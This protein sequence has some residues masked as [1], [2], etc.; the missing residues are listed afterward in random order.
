MREGGREGGREGREEREEK[1]ISRLTSIVFLGSSL[2]T[3]YL[4]SSI[5]AL[6][7][8]GEINTI[9]FTVL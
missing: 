5:T 1:E 9:T 2:L 4:S 7:A 8:A 6:Q 3:E